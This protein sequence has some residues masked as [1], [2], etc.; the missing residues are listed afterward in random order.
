MKNKTLRNAKT[1]TPAPTPLQ[2]WSLRYLPSRYETFDVAP[3]RDKFAAQRKNAE[4][5]K[6][7]AVAQLRAALLDILRE[8]KDRQRQSVGATIPNLS[9][10][11]IAKKAG[12]DR[13]TLGRPYH[14]PFKRGLLKFIARYCGRPLIKCETRKHS[15]SRIAKLS[16]AYDE[17][18]IENRLLRR[19]LVERKNNIV[20]LD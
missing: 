14:E 5:Q 10:S 3:G 8:I 9:L 1:R 16:K 6:A 11:S 19:C 7:E 20:E 4:Q 15:H 13:K 12:V 17:L 2:R 18:A